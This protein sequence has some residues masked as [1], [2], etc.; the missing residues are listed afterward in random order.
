M[1]SRTTARRLGATDTPRLFFLTGYFTLSEGLGSE[2][3]FY[4]EHKAFAEDALAG[5]PSRVA[6]AFVERATAA[7]D[8]LAEFFADQNRR[9]PCLADLDT[10]AVSGNSCREFKGWGKCEESWLVRGGYCGHTCGRCRIVAGRRDAGEAS[11]AGEAGSAPWSA[12][13]ADRLLASGEAATRD[14]GGAPGA[15]A[16]VPLLALLREE[17]GGERDPGGRRRK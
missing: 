4:P 12:L 16:A 8:A 6:A 14:E 7:I 9:D 3:R 2:L 17:A 11:E 1:R 10:A 15:A 13:L 5:F